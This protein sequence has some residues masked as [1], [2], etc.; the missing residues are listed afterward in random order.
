MSESFERWLE[1]NKC[2]TCQRK[3]NFDRCSR[4]ECP[5]R[6]AVSHPPTRGFPLLEEEKVRREQ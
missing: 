3:T 6:R 1:E 5:K 4:V 2:Q